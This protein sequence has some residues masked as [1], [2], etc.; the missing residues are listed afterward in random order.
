MTNMKNII[1]QAAANASKKAAEEMVEV[2]TR[3]IAESFERASAYNNILILACY[4]S[5]FG[6]WQLTKGMVDTKLSLWAALLMAVSAGTFVIFE[7]TKTFYTSRALNKLNK[8]MLGPHAGNPTALLNAMNDYNAK[9]KTVGLALIP[10]WYF[11]FATSVLT[12]V[13]AL[14]ILLWTFVA[15]LV[16]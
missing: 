7:V 2:Q 16:A 6:L 1:E 12:G 4:A 14:G 11:S 9:A 5:F 10:F 3:I 13:G 8:M 15:S